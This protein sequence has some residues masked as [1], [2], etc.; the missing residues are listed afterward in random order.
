MS[1]PPFKVLTAFALALGMWFV[2]SLSTQ[3]AASAGHQL[4]HTDH[5]LLGAANDD[6]ALRA[7]DQAV[8]GA[9][10]R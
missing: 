10:P 8:L 7:H 1:R 4:A 9:L 2:P 3:G 6:A 5:Q